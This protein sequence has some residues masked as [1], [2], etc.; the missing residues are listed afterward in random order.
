M[1]FRTKRRLN[2]I[3]INTVYNSAS[4]TKM[5]TAIAIMQLRDQQKLELDDPVSKYVPEINQS[6]RGTA[7][8]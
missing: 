5:F 8:W 1:A 7:L 4:C 2:P 3:D 6:P